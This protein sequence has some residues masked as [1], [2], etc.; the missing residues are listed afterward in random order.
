MSQL[1]AGLARPFTYGLAFPAVASVPDPAAGAG[2]LYRASGAYWERPVSLAFHLATSAAVAD[3]AVAVSILDADGITIASIPAASVIAASASVG[4]TFL[5][6]VGG[7]QAIEGVTVLNT[8]PDLFLQPE[9]L[10]AVT[11][12]AIDAAD[13]ISGVRYYRE[14]FDTGSEGYLTGG[15]DSSDWPRLAARR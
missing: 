7:E 1:T 8:L 9:W 12:G 6:T 4:F 3:R 14:L 13:Q 2:V 10:L 15:I 11:V 5:P